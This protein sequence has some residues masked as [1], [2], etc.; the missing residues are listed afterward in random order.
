MPIDVLVLD[1]QDDGLLGEIDL[2]KTE[3]KIREYLENY[4]Q[5]F[6]RKG[7]VDI[8]VSGRYKNVNEALTSVR[9]ELIKT[10][11]E[12]GANLVYLWDVE[13]EFLNMKKFDILSKGNPEEISLRFK[14]SC[15]TGLIKSL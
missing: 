12:K 11:K 4:N 7:F 5:T 6:D 2:F 14:G 13:K 10:V 15:Y 3:E 9:K 1:I 8:L